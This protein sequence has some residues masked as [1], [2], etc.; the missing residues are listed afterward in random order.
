MQRNVSNCLQILKCSFK[1]FRNNDKKY[2]NE[3]WNSIES[4]Q[5]RGLYK[6]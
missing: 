2:L 1:F 4:Y 6:G 3:G 5:G